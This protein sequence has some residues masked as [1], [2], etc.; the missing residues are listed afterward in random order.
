M[1]RGVDGLCEV[2]SGAGLSDVFTQVPPTQGAQLEK[3][4][5]KAK[6]KRRNSTSKMSN[7]ILFLRSPKS[8]G[9]A[10][11]RSRTPPVI[12]CADHMVVARMDASAQGSSSVAPNSC[13]DLLR[14]GAGAVLVEGMRNVGGR[15]DEAISSFGEP[16][17]ASSPDFPWP[18]DASILGQLPRAEL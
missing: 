11:A 8:G 13:P 9:Q 3:K 14:V 7:Y 10:I 4:A 6:L 18:P 15:S 5:W 1:L 17:F 16:I 12:P 2:G